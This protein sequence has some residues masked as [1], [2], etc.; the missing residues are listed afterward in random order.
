MELAVDELLRYTDEERERWERWFSD[1]GE[2]LLKVPIQSDRDATIGALI[3]HIF[4]AE[5]RAVQRLRGEAITEYRN[6][7]RHHIEELFGFGIESR[8]EFRRFVARANAAEW[9]MVVQFEAGG[10][11]YSAS[12]RK[13]IFNVLIHEI[14]HWA[15]VARLLRERG[16]VPPGNHDLLQSSALK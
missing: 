10:K 9:H 12:G 8:N 11:H 13:V 4:G 14:R 5:L 1:N 2:D 3:L 16:F 7:P 15:Q 6:R